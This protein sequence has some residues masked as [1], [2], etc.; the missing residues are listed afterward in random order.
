[1]A[2]R[3]GSRD[4][5]AMM[6]GSIEEYVPEDAPVRVYDA[7]V[8]VLDLG[9]MG[10]ENDPHKEGNPSY[11]PVAMLKLLVYGYSYGVR[12]SRRLEREVNY[13]LS[14]MWL[15]GGL[16]PDFKT[17]AEF[18]RKNRGALKRVLRESVRLCLRLDLIAGNTLF[19]D[20]S[21]M[22]ANASMKNSWSARKSTEAMAK[23]D[24]RIEDLL[25]EAE[26]ID[27]VE[28][29]EPSLV[30]I[31]QDLA[32]ARLRKERIKEIMEDLNRDAANSVNTVDRDCVVVHGRQGSHAGY[33]A[34]VV[35]DDQHGLIVSGDIAESANNDLGQFSVQ[36]AKANETLGRRCLIGVADAGYADTDDLA[37][38]VKDGIKV[39]VPSKRIASKKEPNEFGKRQFTYSAEKDCYTC[40]EGHVLIK[41]G[42]THAGNGDRYRITNRAL[43]LA[44]PHYG[45]CTKAI[46][47][48]TIE[49]LDAEI[50]RENLEKEYALSENLAIYKRRQ[51]RVE[52][53]FGHIK[54]NLGA[55][56]FL[57]RGLEGVRAEMG[58]LSLCFNLRRMITLLGI[59][60]MI[61]KLRGWML[62]APGLFIGPRASGSPFALCFSKAT[63]HNDRVLSS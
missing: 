50:L 9:E 21:K 31:R 52:L 14:F 10:I 25:A 47:G 48:R 40:P 8:D 34:Q 7:F 29:G 61:E 39:I 23:L 30:K 63:F 43:C 55:G 1:M 49:R 33:N 37:K 60:V 46:R 26:A 32:D 19:V 62:Q 4:Q 44:C 42:R 53:I 20:G 56:S 17:I 59:P 27:K 5:I 41:H 28:E 22:R 35:V 54:R 3:K 38:A 16:K 2:I 51:E 45:K 24:K 18:R 57:L 11:D 6:P 13:N 15:M 12:S 36:I 58:L